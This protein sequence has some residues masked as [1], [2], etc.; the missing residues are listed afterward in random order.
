MKLTRQSKVKAA[1]R[2]MMAVLLM[3]PCALPARAAADASAGV[4]YEDLDTTG[5]LNQVMEY[6]GKTYG[7]KNAVRGDIRVGNQ[8]AT[9]LF[10][11]YLLDIGSNEESGGF[12]ADHNA[13]WK[14]N[15]KYQ[16]LHHRIGYM[17]IGEIHSG[18]W[19]PKTAITLR[20]APDAN[21]LIRRTES[22]FGVAYADP[23]NSAR[24]LSAQY[25]A[26]EKYGSMS[27]SLTGSPNIQRTRVEVDNIKRDFTLGL[28]SSI[29]EASAVSVDFIHTNFSDLASKLTSIADGGTGSSNNGGFVK[30]PSPNQSMNA[31]EFKFRHDVSKNFA[32]TGAFTGHQRVNERTNFKHDAVVGALNAA[33]AATKTL[34]L[35]SKLYMQALQVEENG[36]VP[37][38]GRGDAVIRTNTHQLDKTALRGEFIV[39]YRPVEKLR[40][41]GAYKIEV[42]NRRDAPSKFY[43]PDRYFVDGYFVQGAANNEVA[44]N[45]TKHTF[46]AT[47]KVELPLAM[48]V[49]AG[50][51]KMQANFP[52]FINMPTKQD[53]VTGQWTVP[54]PLDVTLSFLGG[55]LKERNTRH[56]FE[57]YNQTR[58][59]Y[60]AGLDWAATNKMFLGVDASYETVRSFQE[61]YFG[62]G[63]ATP[64]A[65]TSFHT[66]A[67]T[68][69]RNTIWGAHTKVNLPKGFVV[70]GNG[71]YTR[72][73]V[74]TPALLR[75]T[76]GT[77]EDYTPTNTAIARGSA[78][79]EFTPERYKNL[80]AR[81][82]YSVSDWV[83]KFDELNS[84]RASVAQ[85]GVAMKF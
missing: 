57:H 39:N 2:V 69:T 45:D 53:E 22:E 60:R 17:R 16:T 70:M 33:Y 21:L 8:G 6:N 85:L 42:T 49:E 7:G 80:T 73:T 31:A 52:A 24:W 9:G 78:A 84:G 18:S 59:T 26:A 43:A 67:L 5:H 68:Q 23:A 72:S 29:R 1:T 58:N 55:Y 71:S 82:S 76:G 77:L 14:L 12:N 38:P 15:A 32:V 54:L 81:A 28:G 20:D 44:R 37:E 47:A 65:T 48:E 61:W 56:D 83:D 35:T 11:F 13:G 40:L 79:V 74:K 10:D 4:K 25:W 27:W 62:N 34:S 63:S 50:Y 46:N 36:Y 41:K 51:K 19:L 30:Y 66:S 64:S 75:Y 3:G